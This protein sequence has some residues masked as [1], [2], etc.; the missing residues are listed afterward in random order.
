MTSEK[1]WELAMNRQTDRQK[2][3]QT[4][5]EAFL[6]TGQRGLLNESIYSYTEV[7]MKMPPSL[8]APCAPH[9][10]ARQSPTAHEEH[11]HNWWL[12]ALS[13]VTCQPVQTER[14]SEQPLSESKQ[15][16]KE[17]EINKKWSLFKR[18]IF[19]TKC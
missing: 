7:K 2:D 6:T 19:I 16:I 1:S 10:W 17:K 3:R 11:T 4:G 5:V 15:L 9:L 18:W 14:K 8:W 13:M 12:C